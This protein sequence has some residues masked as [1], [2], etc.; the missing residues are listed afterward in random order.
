[1]VFNYPTPIFRIFLD[2]EVFVSANFNYQDSSFTKL[3]DLVNNDELVLYITTV[4]RNEILS[5][6]EKEVH[7]SDSS[8]KTIHKE[9]R[10]NAKILYNYQNFKSLFSLNHNKD[11]TCQELK[12]QFLNYLE[13]I[14]AQVISVDQVSPEDIFDQYFNNLPPFKEG[15]KKYE[16]P[17]AFSIAALEKEAMNNDFKIYVISRD[18]DWQKACEKKII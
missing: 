7:N 4:T 11:E 5:N 8:L 18:N 15:K 2:T 10:K 17:D 3:V 13:K 12:N 14:K 16:F 6:I 1:M 9:F